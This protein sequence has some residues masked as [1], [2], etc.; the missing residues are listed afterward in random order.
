MAHN[1][2]ITL[3]I[4]SCK[5]PRPFGSEPSLFGSF[6][7]HEACCISSSKPHERTESQGKACYIPLDRSMLMDQLG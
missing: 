1:R 2:N 6:D 4:P 7:P 3:A 5:R